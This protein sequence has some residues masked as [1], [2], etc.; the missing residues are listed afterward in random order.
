M[1]SLIIMLIEFISVFVFALLT[2]A[3]VTEVEAGIN[4]LVSVLHRFGQIAIQIVM[5]CREL[6]QPLTVN[7]KLLL[8][9][10]VV[11]RQA[12][13]FLVFLG[14]EIVVL[15][16]F[17]LF[18]YIVIFYVYGLSLL[19]KKNIFFIIRLFRTKF[20]KTG[21]FNMLQVIKEAKIKAGTTKRWS[22]VQ[23][24]IEFFCV[25]LKVR[26]GPFNSSNLGSRLRN[27]HYGGSLRFLSTL[28]SIAESYSSLLK[29][30]FITGFCDA[31]ACFNL[32]VKKSNSTKTGWHVIPLFQIGLHLKD[33][34]LLK[35]IQA[36]FECGLEGSLGST[37]SKVGVI[38][39]SGN[40]VYYSVSSVKELTKIIDHFDNYPLLTKKRLDYLIWKIAVL[41]LRR[42]DHLMA[43]GLRAIVL[44]KAALNLGLSEN[45]LTAFQITS[46]EVEVGVLNKA[47][48][49]GYDEIPFNPQ[50]LAGFTSGDGNFS[51]GLHSN[52]V[53]LGLTPRLIFQLT[54]HSRDEELLIRLST[55]LGCGAVRKSSQGLVVI[56]SIQKFADI[57]SKII[58][59][60]RENLIRGVKAED[61]KDWCN[62]AEIIQ[63]KGHLTKGGLDQIVALRAGMNKSR[64][65]QE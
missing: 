8:N 42:K 31:E 25:A 2:L 33:K 38:R 4:S 20:I 19:I 18:C 37:T 5:C 11:S 63:S 13:V 24:Y 54:Q 30:W 12:N 17:S 51:I 53:N 64:I 43:E 9:Y 58:P 7:L 50:W 55:W 32:T 28:S 47:A 46:T 62:A 56:F 23:D 16:Q 15:V 34:E 22:G 1:I 60:F 21:I 29:P 48:N 26:S 59:L 49:L 3:Y 65:N 40:M 61:F 6:F 41:S 44:L 27:Y 52:T 14:P 35:Q 57:E 45:L 39:V 36:F 10:F